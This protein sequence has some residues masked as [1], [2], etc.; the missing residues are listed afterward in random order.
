[1]AM[2]ILDALILNTDRHSG[3]FGV[4]YRN[5]TMQVQKM[6]PVFD[7]NR[8]L[9][10]DLDDDQLKHTDWCIR[11]CSPGWAWIHCNRQR[12][13]DGYHPQRPEEPAKFPF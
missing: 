7:S 13:D 12:F 5:D 10:F 11:H 2:C 9:L 3:N 1:M 6:A 4:L 8:S